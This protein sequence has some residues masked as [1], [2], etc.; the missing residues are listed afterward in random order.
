MISVNSKKQLSIKTGQ[1]FVKDQGSWNIDSF[2]P[3]P[4]PFCIFVSYNSC[5]G[6]LVP[7]TNNSFS[8]CQSCLAKVMMDTMV[9]IFIRCNLSKGIFRAVWIL[10]IRLMSTKQAL[11]LRELRHANTYG[12]KTRFIKLDFIQ[13]VK[14]MRR[15]SRFVCRNLYRHGHRM[16]K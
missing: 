8:L 7:R 13:T 1:T 10:T 5:L 12:C 16:Q 11:I 4:L 3:F 15:E 6:M 2:L 9:F 14:R